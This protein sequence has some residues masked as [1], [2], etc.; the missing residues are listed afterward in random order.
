MNN[1]YNESH[2]K[3]IIGIFLDKCF[4]KDSEDDPKYVPETV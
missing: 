4:N 1:G 3:S 2:I